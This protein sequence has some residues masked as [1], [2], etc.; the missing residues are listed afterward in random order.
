VAPLLRADPWLRCMDLFVMVEP[1][2]E[3]RY[4][5][6]MFRTP[7]RSYPTNIQASDLL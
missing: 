3:F 5:R 1:S 6:P 2:G 4:S 7:C